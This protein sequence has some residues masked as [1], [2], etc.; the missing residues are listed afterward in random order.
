MSPGAQ[1][2][3][4]AANSFFSSVLRIL[5]LGLRGR[6]SGQNT[7]FTGV[8]NAASRAATHPL[9]SSSVAALPGARQT[10]AAGSSPSVLCGEGTRA[11]SIT[12]GC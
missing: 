1:A 2:S 7:T 12:A 4:G 11:A 5:P 9:I 8:L 3:A 6:G 10:T